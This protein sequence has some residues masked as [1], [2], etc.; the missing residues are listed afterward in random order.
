MDSPN[1]W[2]MQKHVFRSFFQSSLMNH[3]AP[4][5]VPQIVLQKVFPDLSFEVIL[6]NHLAHLVV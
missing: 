4:L 6:M 5:V 1:A 3:F 2:N